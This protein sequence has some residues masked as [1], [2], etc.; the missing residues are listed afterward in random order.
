MR[1]NKK[2]RSSRMRKAALAVTLAVCTAATAVP[3]VA[4]AAADSSTTNVSG[5]TAAAE[6]PVIT[7]ARVVRTGASEA[8]ISFEASAAGTYYYCVQDNSDAEPSVSDVVKAGKEAESS[9]Q[10]QAEAGEDAEPA[11]SSEAVSDGRTSIDISGI[12]EDEQSVY[13]VLESS[14]GDRS[15]VLRTDVPDVTASAV[16][17][18]F[19]TAEKGYSSTTSQTVTVTNTSDKTTQIEAPILTTADSESTVNEDTSSDSSIP[20]VSLSKDF[21]IGALTLKD[22]D[23]N[24]L[25]SSTSDSSTTLSAGES[26]SFDITPAQDLSAGT[27]EA[28]LILNSEDTTTTI[29]VTFTVEDETTAVSSD[30]DEDTDESTDESSESSSKTVKKA[31]TVNSKSS[32]SGKLV[33]KKKNGKYYF[34]KGGKL[35]KNR[36]VTYKNHRYRAKKSGAL[37]TSSFYIMN[38]EKKYYLDKYGRLKRGV[39]YVGSK[40]YIAGKKYGRIIREARWIKYNNQIY[41]SNSEGEIYRSRFIKFGTSEKYYASSS[42]AIMRGYFFVGKDL[43][44][45]DSNTGRISLAKQWITY[46]SK[47]YR[48][49]SSGEI[50]RSRF[51]TVG[52]SIYYAS[53]TGAIKTGR[54]YVGSSLYI[55]ASKTGQIEK[56]AK[57]IKYSGKK[58]RQSSS[59]VIYRNRL[60]KVG[61]YK[62]YAGKSGV[63]LTGTFMRK[64]VVYVATSSGRITSI[65]KHAQGIDVSAYQYTINWKKVSKDSKD[66]EYAFIKVGGRYGRTGKIYTDSRAEANLR[67]AKAYGLLTGVYFFTQAITEKEARAEADFACKWADKYNTKLPVV[68]DTESLSGSRH[69][70]LSRSKRTKVVKAF[71]EE[72][73]KKGFTP[74][75]Y[76]NVRWLNH[77]LYMSQLSDYKVWVAQ[78]NSTLDYTGDCDYWQYS[79]SGSVSGISGRV[80]MNKMM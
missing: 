37:Y 60:I 18:D 64:G 50:Y 30:E 13:L 11:G 67:Q 76:S 66:I 75:I 73:E 45:S 12:E 65:E 4:F 42:G 44:I 43:Y 62:Y 72:V 54:F 79:S 78:Y 36:W 3:Q 27:H 80:D 57:W 20:T 69:N 35:L 61:K 2:E 32:S 39:F 23:G 74:M 56:K 41:R 8:E 6:E 1:S 33:L 21:T 38:S 40:K 70:K 59:G 9:E 10:E 77:N 68:I 28:L 17:L 15:S 53:S 7:S 48:Q 55:A 71:C 26:V 51:V 31:A 52:N 58:Y 25:S 46:K 14:A 19:G 16:S 34:Y 29:S 22:A 24:V 49:S 63:I 5:S 47:R